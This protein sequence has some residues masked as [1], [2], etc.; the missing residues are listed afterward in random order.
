MKQSMAYNFDCQPSSYTL[1]NKIVKR[2][3]IKFGPIKKN[4]YPL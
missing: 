2:K 4:E 1:N 3:I